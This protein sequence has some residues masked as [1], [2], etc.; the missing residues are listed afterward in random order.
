MCMRNADPCKVLSVQQFVW[1]RETACAFLKKER[2]CLYQNVKKLF[3][4]LEVLNFINKL[5]RPVF[6][7]CNVTVKERPADQIY[8]CI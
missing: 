7:C 6:A 3:I 1:T 5:F 8:L 2:K 4:E